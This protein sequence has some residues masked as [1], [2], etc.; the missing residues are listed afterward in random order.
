MPEFFQNEEITYIESEYVKENSFIGKKAKSI[1]L[2]KYE[3]IKDKLPIPQWEGHDNAIRCY[4]RAWEIA[5]G[6]L[7]N[8]ADGS[9][10][11]SPFID[12][13]F[14]GCIFMWDSSFILMF[15][16]YASRLFDFQG[17]LDNFYALQHKDGFIS[18]EI[19]FKNGSEKF[20]RFDPASTGPNI[21]PWSEY[22]YYKFT[23]NNERMSKIFPVL[24]AYHK[25]LKDFHT[26]RDGSYW[27]S[28]WGCGMDN[29]PRHPRIDTEYTHGKMIWSDTCMQ[30]ILSCNILIKMAVALGREN[31]V[32]ELDEERKKLK[33]LI[34]ER[35]WDDKTKFYYDM[36]DDDQLTMVKSVGA[37]WALI[38][39][40]ADSERAD[41][42]IAHL[43]NPKEFKTKNRV[44]TLS[45][46]DPHYRKDGFYWRG[47]VWA[48]TNYMVL[49]GLDKYGKYDMAYEIARCCVENVVENFNESNTLWENYEPESCKQGSVSSGDFVGW[50]GLFPISIMIEYIFGIKTD[51]LKRE[52]NWH[53]NLTDEFG[54]EQYPY[55][56]NGLIDFKC[57]KRASTSEEP[58]IHINSNV[59][60][61]VNIFWDGGSKTVNI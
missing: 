34:N 48:P 18:R 58:K 27:S 52:I 6:N 51:M 41:E 56:E 22:E 45:A 23:G 15:G 24:L 54:I 20:T 7:L 29:T 10:F 47:S 53:I 43:D 17:T 46:D 31:D 9:G 38:A 60:V 16:K 4:Y 50:S 35:L 37:Y 28:G 49:C 12:T 32:N 33:K 5:F 55:G 19:D 42:L 1:E 61:K 30:Q 36:L 40:I 44:P 57:E 13:A 8:P 59:N 14:N 25:W 21:M 39:E 3:D 2:P 26:W 11:I